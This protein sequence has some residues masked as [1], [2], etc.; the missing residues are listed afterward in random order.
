MLKFKSPE[1]EREFESE[2]M[3][4]P[5]LYGLIHALARWVGQVIGRDIVITDVAR[6]DGPLTSPHRIHEG[7]PRSRAADIRVHGGYFSAAQILAIQYWLRDNFP[8][9][10]MAR[11][12]PEGSSPIEGWIGTSRHHGDGDNEHLHVAVEERKQFWYAIGYTPHKIG[13]IKLHV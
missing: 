1:V 5:R 4:D 12:E 3:C 10:D 11:Y 8:R 9:S 2:H 6:Y 13:A 7:N